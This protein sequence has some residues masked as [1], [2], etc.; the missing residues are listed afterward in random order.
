MCNKEYGSI[1]IFGSPAEITFAVDRRWHHLARW[2]HLSFG[3]EINAVRWYTTGYFFLPFFLSLSLSPSQSLS[4]VL[5]KYDD[6][7][8]SLCFLLRDVITVPA[9]ARYWLH[10]R[11]TLLPSP[12]FLSSSLLPVPASLALSHFLT[13]LLPPSVGPNATQITAS[14]RILRRVQQLGRLLPAAGT[15][16]VTIR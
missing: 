9:N 1:N 13:R 8:L 6:I 11:I 3:R 10:R 4:L 15:A 14:K 2:Q 12:L 16:A 5:Q 7:A